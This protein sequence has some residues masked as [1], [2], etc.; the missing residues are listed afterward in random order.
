[1]FTSPE[2][3]ALKYLRPY[4]D[5]E[6][7]P[8]YV[9]VSYEEFGKSSAINHIS[10]GGGLY[11]FPQTFPKSGNE[12]EDSKAITDFINSNRI[13]A[14][15]I[16][17][18]GSYWQMWFTGFDPN[19]GPDPEMKNKLLPKLLPFQNTGF[20]QGLEHFELVYQDEWNYVLI[21]RVT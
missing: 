3:E 19:K 16:V 7:V 17:N 18:F 12:E 15:T 11:I 2:D 21:Y 5:Y 13:E 14:M 4:V 20:G 6:N 9:L 10:Q 8:T 1:M